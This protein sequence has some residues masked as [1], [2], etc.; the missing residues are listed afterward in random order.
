MVVNRVECE[1]EL[2]FTEAADNEEWEAVVSRT[3]FA[4]DRHMKP[5]RQR[6]DKNQ[7]HGFQIS[8]RDIKLSSLRKQPWFSLSQL[9]DHAIKVKHGAPQ[10]INCKIYPLMRPELEATRKFLNDNLALRFIE[11]CDDR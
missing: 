10:E 8:T 2:T 9:E 5:K 3:N 1:P 4:Q 7:K 11:E 6:R